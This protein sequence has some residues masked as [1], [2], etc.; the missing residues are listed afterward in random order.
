MEECCSRVVVVKRR[1]VLGLYCLIG[2]E[3][4]RV[5]KSPTYLSREVLQYL[6]DSEP[7]Q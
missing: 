5:H 3:I 2:G 1:A 4:G 6:Q 7:E